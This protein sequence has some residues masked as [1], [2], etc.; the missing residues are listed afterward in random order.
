MEPRPSSRGDNRIFCQLL[1]LLDAAMEP[2]P[3]SRGDIIISGKDFAPEG[4]AAMEPRPSSRGDK[5]FLASPPYVPFT[6]QWSH[7][8]VAVV[9]TIPAVDVNGIREPQWSHGLVA[10]VM[11]L[12]DYERARGEDPA[13][14]EPR[15]SSRG[16]KKVL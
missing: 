7:G 5:S 15:P 14:M 6:P 11:S 3:S 10:V 16:D 13:A 9:M 12:L 4:G 1:P 2:R 8:L